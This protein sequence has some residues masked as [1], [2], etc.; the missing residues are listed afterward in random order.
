MY[1]GHKSKSLLFKKEGTVN[2]RIQRSPEWVGHIQWRTHMRQ[3]IILGLMVLSLSM[4]A[5]YASADQGG[6][7][8]H[9]KGTRMKVSGTVSAIQSDLI[10]VKT[11]WVRSG[12]LPPPRRKTWRSVK[13]SRCK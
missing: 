8:G 4:P 2:G 1:H 12:F 7:H 11:P 13:R 10:T 6:T 5:S 3:M 9:G